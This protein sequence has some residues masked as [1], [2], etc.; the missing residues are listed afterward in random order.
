VL[1]SILELSAALAFVQNS[2]PSGIAVLEAVVTDPSGARIPIAKIVL[3]G[4]K[5]ITANTGEDGSVQV[6]IP[7]GSYTLTISHPG[8]ETAKIADLA[9]QAANPP[10]LDVVLQTGHCCDEPPIGEGVGLN[11]TTSDVPTVIGTALVPDAATALKIA[12]PALIKKYGKR[13]I[14]DEKPLIAKL[15]NGIWN[16]HGSRCCATTRSGQRKCVL[17]CFGGGV[18]LELRQSD[19]KILS[20]PVWK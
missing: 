8:F 11:P 13:E 4:E 5:T 12:E 19:G 18:A 16:V 14:E 10:D 15:E 6:Q 9:I 7:Y 20:F 3:N 17:R 1:L 2:N